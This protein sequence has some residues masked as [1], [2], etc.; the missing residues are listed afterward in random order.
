MNPIVKQL[1]GER[2]SKREERE[3]LKAKLGIT[4]EDRAKILILHN[5]IKEINVKLYNLGYRG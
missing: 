4:N 2:E 5:E 1:L 3:K